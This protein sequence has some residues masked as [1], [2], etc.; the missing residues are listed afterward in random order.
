MKEVNIR[1]RKKLASNKNNF[2]N[3]KTK[4]ICKNITEIR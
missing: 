1:Q 4:H 3:S 2:T